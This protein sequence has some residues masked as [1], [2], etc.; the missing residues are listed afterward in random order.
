L[1]RGEAEP[2]QQR[3]VGKGLKT[4]HLERVEKLTGGR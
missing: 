4:A 3:L 2:L 1:N